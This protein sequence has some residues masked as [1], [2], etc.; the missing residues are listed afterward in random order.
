[1]YSSDF[2]NSIICID[3]FDRLD[4]KGCGPSKKIEKA[5]MGG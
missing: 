1:V 4:A 5:A 2:F 3:R